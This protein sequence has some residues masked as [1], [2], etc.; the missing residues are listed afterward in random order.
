MSKIIPLFV[1]VNKTLRFSQGNGKY[2]PTYLLF[3]FY[4]HTHVRNIIKK[5]ESTK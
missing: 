4:S 5:I 2:T 3:F 1:P